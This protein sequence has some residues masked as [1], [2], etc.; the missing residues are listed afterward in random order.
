MPE[1]YYGVN[2]KYEWEGGA[3]AYLKPEQDVANG[4]F[5]IIKILS[6]WHETEG[7]VTFIY[8]VEGILDDGLNEETVLN[9]V[10]SIAFSDGAGE[11]RITIGNLPPQTKITVTEIYDGNSY[12]AEGEIV[13]ETVIE[14]DEEDD[15]GET[16]IKSKPVE[17][18]NNYNEGLIPGHGILNKYTAKKAEDGTFSG[19]WN[20]EQYKDSTEFA[21][22]INSV[23]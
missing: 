16:V 6:N 21:E 12:S 3:Q 19:S 4:S 22:K 5:E 18:K 15:A 14:P 11:Q 9:N 20:A 7:S 10:Y 17:F 8:K 23:S 13:G 2:G 1:L